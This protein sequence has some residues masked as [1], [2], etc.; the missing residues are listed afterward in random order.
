MRC[1]AVDRLSALV[2]SGVFRV[3]LHEAKLA[4]AL[5]TPA[6]ASSD[7]GGAGNSNGHARCGLVTLTT[8][9][10]TVTVVLCLL[11]DSTW[12]Q[13]DVRACSGSHGPAIALS[14]GAAINAARV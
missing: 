3:Q 9:L 4:R 11:L 5:S 10:C 13:L 14:A 7:T 12:L 1:E 2:A 8:Y 6:G